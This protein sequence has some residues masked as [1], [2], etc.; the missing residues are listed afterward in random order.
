[1]ESVALIWSR[2][3][4]PFGAF[5]RWSTWLHARLGRNHGIALAT[6]AELLFSYLVE[7]LGLD[8]QTVANAIYRDYQRG[9]RSDIRKRR[10]GPRRRRD[11]GLRLPGYL[12]GNNT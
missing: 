2:D 5:M 4:S 10:Q 1:M 11:D 3:A 9:G 8:P 6:L 7:E 12:A